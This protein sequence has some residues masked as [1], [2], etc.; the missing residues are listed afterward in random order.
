MKIQTRKF[1]EID[2][3]ENLILT[4]PEGLPGFPGFDRFILIE[5][6]E[7]TPF[8]WFQSIEQP[9]L[10]LV[11]MSPFFFKPD[12]EPELETIIEIR[13]WHGVKKEELQVFVVVNISGEGESKTITANLMGPIVVNQKTKEAV[14]FVFSN[15]NYSHQHD[16]LKS[17]EELVKCSEKQK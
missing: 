11:I 13:N 17:L 16:V 12:Y 7:T 1:G 3:D 6:A 5:K 15:S 14:Q 4:M 10:N 8:C 2:I 9:N